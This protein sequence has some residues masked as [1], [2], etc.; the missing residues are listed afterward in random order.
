MREKRYFFTLS[1]VQQLCASALATKRTKQMMCA[2]CACIKKNLNS[3]NISIQI[4][5]LN[6]FDE[7]QKKVVLT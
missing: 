1:N 6:I 3:L 4:L 5:V 2:W 7:G